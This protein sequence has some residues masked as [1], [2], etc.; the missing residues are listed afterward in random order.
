MQLLTT[1]VSES[2]KTL[3]ASIHSIDLTRRYFSRAIGL[4][5]GEIQF[6]LPVEKLTDEILHSL[7]DLKE[8]NSQDQG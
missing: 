6:D 3:V 1:I 5:Q 8:V 2:D 4:R 7:Y